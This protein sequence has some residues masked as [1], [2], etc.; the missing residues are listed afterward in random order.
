MA[1]GAPDPPYGPVQGVRGAGWEPA[2]AQVPP[3]SV[4]PLPEPPRIG[5]ESGPVQRTAGWW[6][7]VGSAA[8][9]Y[10]VRL[11][12]AGAPL[13]IGAL[14]FM[15]GEDAGFIGLGIA[16]IPALVVF[17]AYAPVMLARDGQTVGN[18]A[19]GIRVVRSDGT[20]LSGAQ[21]F[22]REVLVKALLFEGVGV[23]TLYVLTL[24]DYL[25]PLWDERGQA[26][27]DKMVDTLTVDA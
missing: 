25:W 12:L 26:L 9:D 11:L 17:V 23:F 21:A 7:R 6:Q 4:F 13:A 22:V 27:H 1:R 2:G 3:P 16:F 20:T 24:L 18:R 15:V 8:V 14:G 5:R 19:V 10:F